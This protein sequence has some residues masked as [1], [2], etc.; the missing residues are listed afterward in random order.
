[1]M[2]VKR[3]PD[4]AIR[5]FM[6]VDADKRRDARLAPGYVLRAATTMILCLTRVTRC[7]RLRP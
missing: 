1:M 6:F 7:T 5:V 2:F 3:R 4:A